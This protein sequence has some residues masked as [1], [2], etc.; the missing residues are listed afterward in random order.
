MKVTELDSGLKRVARFDHRGTVEVPTHP[1]CYVLANVVDDVLYIGLTNNLCRR[2]MQ[3]LSDPRM[4]GLTSLGLAHW[5]YFMDVPRDQLEWAEGSL[6][7]RYKFQ[8]VKLP[9]LN[10]TGP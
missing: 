10:R 3:H 5:F 6:L 8:E 1:G 9:I 4:T 2:F 7:S